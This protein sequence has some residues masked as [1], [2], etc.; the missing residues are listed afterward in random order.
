MKN[1]LTYDDV[2]RDSMMIFLNYINRQYIKNPDYKPHPIIRAFNCALEG[3]NKI[4]VGE[5]T[6]GVSQNGTK[7][8]VYNPYM[9]ILEKTEK[10]INVKDIRNIKVN[11]SIPID[12]MILTF[13]LQIQLDK[14][15][16]EFITPK[17]M[18]DILNEI[19]PGNNFFYLGDKWKKYLPLFKEKFERGEIHY[20]SDSILAEEMKNIKYNIPWQE[21]SNR[22]RAFIGGAIG[23]F[24]DLK[25][26]KI[27]ITSPK[28]AKIKKYTVFDCAMEFQLGK[29]SNYLKQI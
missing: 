24:I 1:D 8:K 7:E 27:I 19:I 15:K 11:K 4:E 9:V 17:Q 3:I 29:T 13:R 20:P 10:G 12:I 2:F 5:T 16:D 22:Q 6:A 26:R 28:N 21:Y 14:I 18:V 23:S 25:G